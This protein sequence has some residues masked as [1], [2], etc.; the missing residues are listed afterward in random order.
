[1]TTT[2]LF[3]IIHCLLRLREIVLKGWLICKNKMLWICNNL[4]LCSV[5]TGGHLLDVTATFNYYYGID[6]WKHCQLSLCNRQLRHRWKV[7]IY[8]KC[9]KPADTMILLHIHSILFLQMSHPFNTIDFQSAGEKNPQKWFLRSTNWFLSSTSKIYKKWKFKKWLSTIP[10]ILTKRTTI[11]HLKS[12]N[13]KKTN[14]DH[15]VSFTDSL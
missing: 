6:W 3:E 14:H 2:S 1:M 11:S 15:Y 4:L 9:Y 5:A 12:W 7:L 13:A 10:Q 8:A